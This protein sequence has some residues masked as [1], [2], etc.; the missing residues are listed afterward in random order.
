MPS[1]ALTF[2]WEPHSVLRDRAIVPFPSRVVASI[3][4]P[5][6]LAP[7]TFPQHS[8]FHH[9]NTVYF[10]SY[11]RQ[12]SR[13]LIAH[14]LYTQTHTAPHIS[15]EQLTIHSGKEQV[16]ISDTSLKLLLLG[17]LWYIFVAVVFKAAIENLWSPLA[18]FGWQSC[19]ICP[20]NWF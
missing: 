19:F 12:L 6:T 2:S 14:C 15:L 4:F 7:N 5:S 20:I 13:F 17:F 9:K 16:F 11:P 8:T 3:L 18:E 1:Y 10:I